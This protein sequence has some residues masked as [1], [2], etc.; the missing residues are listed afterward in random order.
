MMV[1]FPRIALIAMA[2]TALALACQSS[3][4]SQVAT[5]DNSQ[6]TV[7]PQPAPTTTLVD[8]G[9]PDFESVPQ[10]SQSVPVDEVP[11]T[12]TKADENTEVTSLPD[13]T[14]VPFPVVTKEPALSPIPSQPATGTATE[15]PT[16][17]AEL[18]AALVST[19]T[20]EAVAPATPSTD[21]TPTAIPT[22]SPTPLPTPTLLPTS[23]PGTAPTPSP[24]TST[25]VPRAR[26]GNQIGNSAPDFSLPS[27]QGQTHTLASY[28][29]DKNVVLI[30]Y[31]AFW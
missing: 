20:P 8:Q 4:A 25:P 10:T 15:T 31:R 6:D 27:A 19:V 2:L 12:D 16:A 24:P 3:G 7:V 29:N 9:R 26:V 5:V 28:R 14:P 22:S 11:E 23:T 17:A 18:E 1:G 30:F 21:V 13:E